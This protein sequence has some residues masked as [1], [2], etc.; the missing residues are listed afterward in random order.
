MPEIDRAIR[1]QLDRVSHTTLL[2]LS[3]VPS[4]ELAQALGRPAPRGLAKVFYSDS[5]ATSV[6]VALKIAYQYHA[7]KVRAH[8]ARG[9]IDSSASEGRTTATRSAR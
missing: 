6:E 7:Q 4:I 8:K 5:G 9:G 1:E 2:G 3:S